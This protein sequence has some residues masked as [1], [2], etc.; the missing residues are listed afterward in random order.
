M[1]TL[2]GFAEIPRFSRANKRQAL[3]IRK[4][5][6]C[7]AFQ[8]KVT[9][10]IAPDFQMGVAAKLWARFSNAFCACLLF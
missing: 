6:R 8:A 3:R 5:S 4:V 10:V 1:R 2:G 9:V 7:L